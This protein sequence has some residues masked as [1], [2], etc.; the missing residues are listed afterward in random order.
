MPLVTQPSMV[1]SATRTLPRASSDAIRPPKTCFRK[2][3]SLCSKAKNFVTCNRRLSQQRQ[4]HATAHSSQTN[5]PRI[6]PKIKPIAQAV[7]AR[8]ASSIVKKPTSNEFT[9]TMFRCAPR[10]GGPQDVNAQYPDPDMHLDL[11]SVSDASN[12][13]P[14]SAWDNQSTPVDEAIQDLLISRT[15]ALSLE[16]MVDT[17]VAESALVSTNSETIALENALFDPFNLIGI[18]TEIDVP[19]MMSPEPKADSQVNP[20]TQTLR[21]SVSVGD[22]KPPV[23]ALLANLPN[24][25]GD[26]AVP[27]QDTFDV[28]KGFEVSL[29]TFTSRLSNLDNE[30]KV[31][32]SLTPPTALNKTAKQVKI[33]THFKNIA[34]F[35]Y[36][37]GEPRPKFAASSLRR[38]ESP[39]DEQASLPNHDEANRSVSSHEHVKQTD[40]KQHFKNVTTYLKEQEEAQSSAE[41]PA[42]KTM[43]K[44]AD[45]AVAWL[46]DQYS[47][48][49][50]TETRNMENLILEGDEEEV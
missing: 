28:E 49:L 50:N 35:L 18:P 32:S 6:T 40:I 43:N 4:M 15:D 45:D 36:S 31:Q 1:S 7:P 10:T 44:A 14:D 24:A 38:A 33:Q 9:Q 42:D 17:S 46:I 29:E 47:K 11:G 48:R 39:G 2:F 27:A 12:H 3:K 5:S 26:A 22:E 30:G 16:T 21:C 20:D 34:N 23:P 8:V 41:K 37:Q 13:I 25:Q 19:V